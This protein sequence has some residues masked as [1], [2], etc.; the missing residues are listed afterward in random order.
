[1]LAAALIPVFARNFVGTLVPAQ[2]PALVA[3]W[4]RDGFGGVTLRGASLAGGRM[5][6]VAVFLPVLG[7]VRQN[8]AGP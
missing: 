2:L 1:M 7:S 5:V 6:I 3:V 8:G 4:V